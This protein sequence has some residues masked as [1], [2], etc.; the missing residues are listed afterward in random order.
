VK[1]KFVGIVSKD[2][3]AANQIAHYILKN[4][5]QYLFALQEPA[6]SIFTQ[7]LGDISILE[8]DEVVQASDEIITG[9]GW[10]SDFE[11]EGIRKGRANGKKVITHLDHW[12]NY[13]ERF[14]HHSEINLPDELW[15]SDEYSEKIA[16]GL[17]KGTKV[18][19]QPDYY[20]QNQINQVNKF[21]SAQSKVEVRTK[22]RVLFLS[23]P[24]I[25]YSKSGEVTYTDRGP[26]LEM[27]FIS[28]IENLLSD[29][30][31]IRIRPHPSEMK[32]ETRN[33]F[34]EIT[35]SDSL[36]TPLSIDLAWADIVVGIDSYALFV[37]DNASIPTASIA[38]WLG[39]DITIPRGNIKF[40]QKNELVEF[41]RAE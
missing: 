2:A 3:G 13:L 26:D 17:F 33:H 32:P 5:G 18:I 16:A 7:I 37:S 31:D 9:S 19:R 21:R 27:E 25:E 12:N 22:K 28:L 30:L 1:S 38:C 20:L 11:W 36:R 15:V 23:E 14:I 39:L 6:L 40:L 4:S 10:T 8:L 41:L 34:S 24:L 35:E 29:H